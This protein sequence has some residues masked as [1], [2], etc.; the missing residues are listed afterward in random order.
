MLPQP[1][2]KSQQ[3]DQAEL[4]FLFDCLLPGIL[5]R[6]TDVKEDA[7]GFLSYSGCTSSSRDPNSTTRQCEPCKHMR[8]RRMAQHL[9]PNRIRLPE[10]VYSAQLP[11]YK[12]SHIEHLMNTLLE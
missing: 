1:I 3:A 11:L 2:E 12:V 5:V 9:N 7:R 4:C 10:F 8:L 6:T